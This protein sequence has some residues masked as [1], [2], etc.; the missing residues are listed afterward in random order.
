M[1]PD[2]RVRVHAN[3]ATTIRAP[4]KFVF[5]DRSFLL[6]IPPYP[7]IIYFSSTLLYQQQKK[8]VAIKETTQRKNIKELKWSCIFNNS[9]ISHRIK[10][11]SRIKV[12][13]EFCFWTF[14]VVESIIIVL[15]IRRMP[16]EPLLLQIQSM[17]C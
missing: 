14:S 8:T 10:H 12:I 15:Y 16:S 3:P 7:W 5:G 17:T 4:H 6:L 11:G 13:M 2:S 1:K 9:T